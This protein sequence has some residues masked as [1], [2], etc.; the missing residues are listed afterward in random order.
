MTQFIVYSLPRS[1]ST[2]MQLWLHHK[3]G[4]S[5]GHDLAMTCWHWAHFIGLYDQGLTGTCETGAI[6]GWRLLR[7]F[8]PEIKTVVVF[9]DVGEVDASLQKFDIYARDDLVE[10]RAML[11][12]VASLEGVYSL[13]WRELSDRIAAKKLWEFIFEDESWDEDRHHQMCGINAQVNVP[14][15]MGYLH[16]NA[17]RISWMKS[18]V[19]ISLANLAKEGGPVGCA[20]LN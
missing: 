6:V 9:R 3:E 17:E 14:D 15:I 13:D 10:R 8:K 7:H 2:W 5:I 19:Q 16:N 11:E 18:T 20:G 4:L 12:E 1:R